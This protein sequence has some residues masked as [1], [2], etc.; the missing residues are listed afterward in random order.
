MRAAQDHGTG[1]RRNLFVKTSSTMEGSFIAIVH[2]I[3]LTASCSALDVKTSATMTFIEGTELLLP[4]S[5]SLVSD[6][7]SGQPQDT[8]VVLQWF[9]ENKDGQRH[10][11]LLRG[12]NGAVS[13]D[14]NSAFENRLELR[15]SALVVSDVRR[16]DAGVFA[17]QVTTE[18]EGTADS[19]SIV[20]IVVPI[21]PK[22]QLIG[23]SEV[24][25]KRESTEIG[26]C[27]IIGGFP[28][29][30][31]SWLMDGE[32]ALKCPG[33]LLKEKQTSD[34]NGL[35]NISSTLIYHPS[36]GFHRPQF[37]CHVL[38]WAVGKLQEK[39]SGLITFSPQGIPELVR[40]DEDE[41]NVE[42]LRG[43]TSV[44]LDCQVLA[45]PRPNL[46]WIQN[47][48]PLEN[49]E[50]RVE[51]NEEKSFFKSFVNIS[52]LEEEPSKTITCKF[53]NDHG[54]AQKKFH[55]VRKS[56]RDSSPSVMTFTVWQLI[57]LLGVLAFLCCIM[58]LSCLIRSRRK[59]KN[60]KRNGKT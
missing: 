3:A 16:S 43:Q 17:C 38:Y 31:I 48:D 42:V 22:L 20:H 23:T 27:L 1:T 6:E 11:L 32:P 7:P 41:E 5:W 25:A 14:H 59:D 57:A 36:N 53:S 18:K 58:S 49:L 30:N 44:L 50:E 60:L 45:F 9:V 35:V 39:S 56:P 34:K 13:R 21:E 40:K 29:P 4:C 10:R 28:H 2:L 15:G 52:L 47:D 8:P 24:S 19:S 33:V 54:T 26:T 46:S 51:W 55:I 37:S 12:L